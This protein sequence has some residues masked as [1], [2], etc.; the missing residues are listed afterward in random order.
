[1]ITKEEIAQ[2]YDKITDHIGLSHAFYEEC[3]GIN[4]KYSGDILD[5]GCGRGFLLQRVGRQSEPDSR[6][7]GLD[8]SPKLCELARKNN[9]GA[10]IVCGDAENLP[11]GDNSFDVIFMTEAL[12][13]MLD[14][15][16]ALSEVHR[17]LRPGGMFIVTVPN[18]DWAR[19]DFYDEK[20]NKSLQPVDDH[21][22]RFTEIEGYLRRNHFKILQVKGLDNLWYYGPIHNVERVFAFLIPSLQKKMKRLLF[23]CVNEK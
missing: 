2:G 3:V 12:E 14:Y 10:V 16:K 13:H 20:R 18:R 15:D 9:P 8:I 4:K 1:M 7:S 19:Y 6:L 21:F 17:T 23:K 5:I 11:F 22:F